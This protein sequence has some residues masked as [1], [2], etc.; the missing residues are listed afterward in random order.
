MKPVVLFVG[1]LQRISAFAS[2]NISIALEKNIKVWHPWWKEKRKVTP[3]L[4]EEFC[5]GYY[6]RTGEQ[7]VPLM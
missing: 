4:A 2:I 3:E 6:E 1:L 7:V 5:R